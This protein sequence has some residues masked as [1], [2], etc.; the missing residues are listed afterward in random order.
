VPSSTCQE[1]YPESNRGYGI[2]A[3]TFRDS[4]VGADERLL[5]GTLM[6]AVGFVLLIACANLANL[7]LVRG[8][9]RQ[10]EMAVRAAMGAS[11]VRLAWTV[12]SE[13][14]V[15]AA[16]GTLLG[17]LA[18][19]WALDLITASLPEELPFWM[20]VDVDQRIV[21]FAVVITAFTT[22]A[23]GLLPALRASRPNVISDL[24][25]GNRGMSLGPAA[26][27]V[28]ALL[29]V[30][31]VALCLALLVGANLMIRSFL[32]MQRA[33]LGFDDRPLL[34]MRMYLAGDAYDDVKQRGAFFVRAVQ[35]LRELPGVTSA[36]IT[37]SIPGD[38]GGNPVRIVVDGR[39]APGEELGAQVVATTTDLFKTLGL[40][41]IEGRTFTD[42]EAMDP[43]S[44]V[45]IL[46]A[47]LARQLWPSESAVGRRIGIVGGG[48]INWLRV[49]GVVPDVQYE[50]FGEETDQSLLNFFVPY[51]WSAS[52]TSAV[53]LRASGDPALLAEPARTALRRLHGSLPLYDIRTMA[54]VRRFTTWDQ[55]FFGTMMGVFAASALLLACLGVYAL[56][57][58]A[59]RRRTHEIG[60]RLALGA[61]PRK[62]VS[63]FVWQ[64]SR[65]GV[66]GLVV[67]LVLAAGVARALSGS[68]FAVNASDPV[69]FASM[70]GVLLAVVLLASYLPARR[71]ARVDPMVALRVE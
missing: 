26:H 51:A 71:A 57:A 59:A 47:R 41:L 18:A 19:I 38:D 28:Q 54:E 23:I 9:A 34:T 52:R 62:V 35:A 66:A 31:Q 32:S 55:E 29:V 60:V 16:F 53:L 14:A 21:V 36:V 2:R 13:S 1:T 15:I 25:E 50:E 65:I 46:N 5:S 8:A 43:Q 64:A 7:L 6:A 3:L 40:E 12:I 42:A 27:R 49:V 30:G 10:R 61:D 70:G 20:R 68:L 22:L 58:Y 39:T 56:L 45:T 24:K 44:A 69:L 4:Q 63:M 37:T 48:D 33:D 17:T 67:G 11:R